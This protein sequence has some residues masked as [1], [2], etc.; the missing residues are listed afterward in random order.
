M[1]Q[2]ALF[3]PID[4]RAVTVRNRIW[5]SPMCQYS[6][7]RHDGVPTDWHLVH[8]GSFAV[9]GAALVMTEASGVSPE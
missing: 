8:L 5:I 2:P 1:T 4:L 7:D 6:V 3:A 9:G